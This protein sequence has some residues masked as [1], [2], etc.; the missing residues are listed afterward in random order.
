M[1]GSFSRSVIYVILL[2]VFQVHVVFVV[3]SLNQ[4]YEEDGYCLVNGIYEIEPHK[5]LTDTLFDVTYYVES[6]KD[7]IFENR[8]AVANRDALPHVLLGSYVPCVRNGI[9]DLFSSRLENADNIKNP[10]LITYARDGSKTV[11]LLY[12]VVCSGTMI[13]IFVIMCAMCH[14]RNRKKIQK[15]KQPRGVTVSIK[16][17]V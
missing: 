15:D 17:H 14:M 12:S 7:P 10:L 8:V 1:F 11:L 6:Y 9:P 16:N 3:M 13:P 4:Y 2:V 5:R